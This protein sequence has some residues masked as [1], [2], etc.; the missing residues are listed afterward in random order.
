LLDQTSFGQD[1]CIGTIAR[2]S[3]PATA[4]TEG[5]AVFS[6]EQ[7][8]TIGA[9]ASSGPTG[10]ELYPLVA[11]GCAATCAPGGEA[12]G[13]GLYADSKVY[14]IL[15]QVY[16]VDVDGVAYLRGV[17]PHYETADY[18]IMFDSSQNTG[19]NTGWS[20]RIQIST[21]NPSVI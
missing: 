10:A 8:A 21:E 13:G 5:L 15:N 9:G 4:T 7:C 11:G 19:T 17:T 16:H 20:T 6:R 1:N 3:D 14:K 12:C 18:Y 2:L